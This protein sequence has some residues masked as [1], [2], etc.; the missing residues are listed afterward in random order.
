MC[1]VVHRI[2]GFVES[3]DRRHGCMSVQHARRPAALVRRKR[4][5]YRFNTATQE[6]SDKTQWGRFSHGCRS[7]FGFGRGALRRGR[8]R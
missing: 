6:V 2:N 4:G 3:L 7:V 8:G 5:G 1:H